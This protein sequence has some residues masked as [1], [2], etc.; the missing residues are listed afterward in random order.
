MPKQ[1]NFKNVMWIK[2]LNLTA[3]IV[4]SILLVIGLNVLASRHYHRFDFN[5]AHRY[6]LSPETIAYIQQLKDPIDIIVMLSEHRPGGP[7]VLG[8][9]R[10]LLREFAYQGR[11]QPFDKIHVQYI[12]IFQQRKKA[13]EMVHRYNL[14]QEDVIIVACRD[15]QHLLQDSDL[16]QTANGHIIGFKGEQSILSAILNVCSEHKQKV[17]FLIGH[18]EMRIDDA[19]PLRGISAAA[20]ALRHRNI[21]L[22]MLDLTTSAEVPDDIELIVVAGPQ[23]AIMPSE[24]EKL[25]RYLSERHGRMI[26]YLEAG[27]P[28]GLDD[29]FFEWGIRSDD[30]VIFDSG[31]DYQASSGDLLIRR[32]AQHP[33]TQILID[34]QL[35]LL[36]GLCR[37]VYIDPGSPIDEKRTDILLMASSETSWAEAAYRNLNTLRYTPNVDIPGPVGIAVVSEH[38]AGTQLGIKIP[39]GRLLVFGNA[40]MISNNRLSLMGNGI[41]FLNSV[42]WSLNREHFLNIPPRKMEL[43]QLAISSHDMMRLVFYLLLLPVSLFI[44]GLTVYTIRRR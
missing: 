35:A 6:A 18:G 3:Q 1:E 19:D 29:L 24:V 4:L 34:Y 39:T 7:E 40:D 9:V 2:R 27:R 42:N 32:F 26:V 5:R 14:P 12:D 10:A 28:N 44:V 38:N 22:E 43:M 30:M 8:D 41:L 33:I 16:Y 37:P 13:E 11:S 25:R 36:V 17:G 21:V 20:E 31:E 23:V 15:K